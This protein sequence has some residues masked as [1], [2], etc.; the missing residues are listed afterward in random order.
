MWKKIIKACKGCQLVQNIVPRPPLKQNK[1]HTDPWELIALDLMGPM[2]TGENILV[3]TDYYS[4]YF[5]VQIFRST[6]T[7]KVRVFFEIFARHEFLNTLVCDNRPQFTN[8][9]FKEWLNINGLASRLRH[10]GMHTHTDLVSRLD[11]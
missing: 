7:Y 4:I 5:E 9:Q 3:I 11:T 2:P 1:L 8:E 6:T 10:R